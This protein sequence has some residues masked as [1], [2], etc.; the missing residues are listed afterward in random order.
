MKQRTCETLLAG[1]TLA[2][3]VMQSSVSKT[4]SGAMGCEQVGGNSYV[5]GFTLKCVKDLIEDGAPFSIKSTSAPI[6]RAEHSIS[7]QHRNE[8]A[9][10]RCEGDAHG[11]A[12][13]SALQ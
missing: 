12:T 5:S 9:G 7:P 10:Y 4:Q 8:I 3:S 11:V 1:S 6:V 2:Y 13:A